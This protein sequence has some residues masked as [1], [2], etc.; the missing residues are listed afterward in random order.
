[1]SWNSRILALAEGCG[2]A[3]SCGENLPDMGLA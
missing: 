3:V 2:L 1:M